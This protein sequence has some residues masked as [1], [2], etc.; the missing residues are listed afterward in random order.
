MII[1]YQII[2]FDCCPTKGSM[3]TASFGHI[4]DRSL[5][6]AKFLLS[7]LF[8][9]I[10]QS[11]RGTTKDKVISRG[12][13]LAKEMKFTASKFACSHQIKISGKL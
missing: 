10:N 9:N 4:Q 12:R 11:C 1:F 6:D 8:N 3:C 13:K 5:N 7:K 2:N